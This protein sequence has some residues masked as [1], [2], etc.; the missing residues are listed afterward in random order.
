VVEFHET[1]WLRLCRAKCR[2]FCLCSLKRPGRQPALPARNPCQPLTTGRPP[3]RIRVSFSRPGAGA[4]RQGCYDNG[5]AYRP[6]THCCEIVDAVGGVG[7]RR[8]GKRL[9]CVGRRSRGSF[10]TGFGWVA[11]AGVFTKSRPLCQ[12]NSRQ[13]RG[14][15]S[16]QTRPPGIG[17]ETSFGDIKVAPASRRCD[18][19][20]WEIMGTVHRQDACGTFINLCFLDLSGIVFNGQ[21]QASV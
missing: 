9:N 21:P 14:F 4:S 12:F 6:L 16:V 19:V 1:L 7:V 8:S 18:L 3:P 20:L 11:G 15:P 5:H 13:D 17:F 10:K 2:G